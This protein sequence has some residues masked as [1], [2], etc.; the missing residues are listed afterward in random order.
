MVTGESC[1]CT[2]SPPPDADA[3]CMDE[4]PAT[5]ATANR[6]AVERGHDQAPAS[7]LSRAL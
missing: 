5:N 3:P 4:H 6:A 7:N 1:V 2:T